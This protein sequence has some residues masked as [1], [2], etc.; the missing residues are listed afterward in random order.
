MLYISESSTARV[1]SLFASHVVYCGYHV[2]TP[3]DPVKTLQ[4]YYVCGF[5]LQVNLLQL[6]LLD[7]HHRPL[8]TYHISF[9]FT[10]LICFYHQTLHLEQFL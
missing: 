6:Q 5:I 9:N 1:F 7:V 4:R 10:A 3:Y 2:P 8:Q